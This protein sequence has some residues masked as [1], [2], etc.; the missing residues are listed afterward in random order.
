MISIEYRRSALKDIRKLEQSIKKE[1]IQE[2]DKIK[3]QPDSGSPLKGDLE[4]YY[5]YSC[6]FAGVSYRIV[7]SYD[8]NKSLIIIEMIGSRENIYETFK[9]RI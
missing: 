8:C 7:Y 4:G 9:R 2:I 5:S 6:R 3:N 1:L